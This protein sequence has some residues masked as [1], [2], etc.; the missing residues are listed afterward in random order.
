MWNDSD[1]IQTL[2]RPAEV[3][4]GTA[5]DWASQVA[6]YVLLRSATQ[7]VQSLHAMHMPD[8]ERWLS[9]HVQASDRMAALTQAVSDDLFALVP[10][11]HEDESRLRRAVLQL[12]REVHQAQPTKVKLADIAEM[13]ERLSQT[14]VQAAERLSQWLVA[15][16]E[17]THSLVQ[18][19]ASFAHELQTVLRPALRAPLKDASFRRALELVSP[20]VAAN[21]RRERKLPTKFDPDNFERSLFG[22][23]LRASAKTSPLSSF[24][25]TSSLSWC[26]QPGVGLPS[27]RQ[28]ELVCRT[29]LNRGVSARLERAVQRRLAR[30]GALPLRLNP[31]L[32]RLDDGRFR[33]LCDRDLVLLKRPWRE[34]R[35]AQFQLHESVSLVLT[36]AIGQAPM[37]W[38]EWAQRMEQGGVARDQVPGLLDKLL[39][40]DVL[41]VAALSDGFAD[42]PQEALLAQLDAQAAPA[43]QPIREAVQ[44]LCR[45]AAQAREEGDARVEGLGRVAD[46]EQAALETLDEFDVPGLQNPV[47]EDCRATLSS[48]GGMPRIGPHAPELA[49]LKDLREFLGSQVEIS[50]QYVRLRQHFLN[51]FGA[52]GVCE[53]VEDFLTDISDKLVEVNEYGN[54]LQEGPS[55]P[56]TPGALMGV[57]AQVQLVT[58]QD[59]QAALMVVNKVF[60]RPAWLATRFAFGDDA[61]Q[62]LLRTELSDWLQ[63]LSGEAEPVDVMVN[64][65]CNELQAHPRL[66]HRVLAWP[67]EPLQ[68]PQQQQLHVSQLQL[69]HRPDTG[70]L[71]LVERSTGRRI[72]LIYL[73]STFPTANWGVPFALSILTQPY[74]LQR[75]E[76]APPVQEDEQAMEE[77]E[78]SAAA[79]SAAV[80]AFVFEPR[81]QKGQLVLRRASWWVRGEHLRQAW[82]S[83]QGARRMLSVRS[84]VGRH[85]LPTCFFAQGAVA[86]RHDLEVSSE[87]LDGYRKP[88]WVDTRN[89]FCLALLERMADRFEWLSITESLPDVGQSWLQLDGQRHV[90]E[91]QIELLIEAS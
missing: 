66:T 38:S 59:G 19:E 20:G 46:L 82:F 32:R 14:D 1:F 85:N 90:C 8:T 54:A 78:P 17:H 74:R 51:R 83:Q 37:R 79:K 28:D 27:L 4:A 40:R 25:A 31:S 65:H 47:V 58:A 44:A 64:G 35:R 67:G 12:R 23:L 9:A 68:V 73:G 89:P 41:Q 13:S 18:A 30:Q 24:M 3:P 21:A 57:T 63:T 48:D 62:Q 76:P 16:A 80:P 75:P 61:Q 42:E 60:D 29:R 36:A 2:D 50:P 55:A 70:L 15:Q 71:E 56:A 22:Y 81:L 86:Q 6:P 45:A 77:S 72:N 87:V 39:K 34:Q 43:W 10:R 52:G 88:L 11:L 69:L 53:D 5:P 26:T 91:L 7:P 84:E 49:A 33:A